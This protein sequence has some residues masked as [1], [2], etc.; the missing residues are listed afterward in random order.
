MSG[1]SVLSVN[2]GA[3]TAGQG[4]RMKQGFDRYAPDW[5]FHSAARTGT[6]IA[7]PT[8]VDWH[9]RVI[10]ELWSQ[11]DVVHLH[12]NFR[13]AEMLERRRGDKP[14]IIHHHGTMFREGRTALLQETRRRGAIGIVSTLDLYLIAPDELEWLPAP[15]DVDWLATL[16]TPVDDGVIRIGSAPTNRTIKSTDA[17]L[18]A[19]ERLQADYPVELVLIE[20]EDWATCLRR[21][22]T[23]DIF[24]DQVKLGFGCNALE[25]WGMGIPVVAGAADPTLDEYERRFGYL[26]FHHATEATIYDA[27]REL[28]ESPD[29][30]AE[31][32]A[33]GNRYVRTFHDD[34]KVVAQLQ[35]LYRRAHDRTSRRAA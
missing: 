15:Y 2:A 27:L 10:A 26:P 20:R 6:Y 22:A 3:D 32:G 8:D 34:R 31:M 24:F 9:P 7:Y 1:L 19:V 29:L 35:D 28:I 18:A 16:R 13:T 14:T 12:N 5:S 4:I 11:A 21:K 25:A 30:R 23:V 33:V 17:F